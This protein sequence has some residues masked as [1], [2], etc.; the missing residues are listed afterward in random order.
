MD[1]RRGVQLVNIQSRFSAFSGESTGWWRQPEG[2]AENRK[3]SLFGEGQPNPRRKNRTTVFLFLMVFLSSRF[4][5]SSLVVLFLLGM[6]LGD[7][8]VN[9]GGDLGDLA[10]DLEVVGVDLGELAMDLAVDLGMMGRDLEQ[11]WVS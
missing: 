5:L 9:L 4:F 1:F 2:K 10:V 11:I 7:P 3:T 6:D 8:A